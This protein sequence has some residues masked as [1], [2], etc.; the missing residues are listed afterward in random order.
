MTRLSCFGSMVALS[1]LTGCYS[2][3]MTQ[4]GR[5]AIEQQV[6]AAA[7]QACVDQLDTRDIDRAVAYR[8]SVS[9]LEDVDLDWVRACV[10]DRLFRDGIRVT[11]DPTA[12]GHIEAV[13]AFAGADYESTLIGIPLFVPGT[14]VALG[15]ISLYKSRTQIGRARL[16]LHVWREG[17]LALIV[18]EVQDSR[19][20]KNESYLTVI[21]S[22]VS[23]NIADFR[24]PGDE[25]DDE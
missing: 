23:T 21:G 2:P 25:Q 11:E 16:A 15:D 9:T 5:T 20:F 22:F 24:A 1:L 18:P 13:V 19:Y 14:P 7:I 17:H 4:P 8:L 3:M 10:Q 6:T 12:L